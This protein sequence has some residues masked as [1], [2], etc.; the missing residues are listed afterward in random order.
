MEFERLQSD[1]NVEIEDI[2]NMDE[3]GFQLGQTTTNFV[4]YDPAIG[5]P[6]APTPK[7]NQWATIIECVGVNRAIK[8]YLIFIGK[9]PEDHMFP[10]TEELPDVI[11]AFSPKGWTDNELAV[12]WLRRVFVPKTSKQGK[13][14]ILILDNHKSHTTGEFQYYCLKHDI[15]PLYLP[16][17]ASHKLQPLDVGPFSP[18]SAAYV[19]ELPWSPNPLCPPHIVPIL[20]QAVLALPCSFLIPLATGELF[21]NKE[22]CLKRLQGYALS[23]GFTVV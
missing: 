16:A 3:T 15:H 5:R 11:W 21:E 7:S 9:F 6:M 1:Y 14:S 20:E 2:Y 4:V 22:D 10:K 8:P 13:H 17:L 19:A 12:D 23:A 18:L